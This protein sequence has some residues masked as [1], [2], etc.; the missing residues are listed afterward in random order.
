MNHRQR[1][2]TALRHQEPDRVPIDFGGTVDT[3]IQAVAYKKLRKHLDG[4]IAPFIPDF[5]EM[6]V[7]IL[8][9]VQVSC[10]GMDTGFLKGF[11]KP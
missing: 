10:A 8:N 7:D 4:A 3:T 9:P 6:G 11:R 5:I 1:I 2:L